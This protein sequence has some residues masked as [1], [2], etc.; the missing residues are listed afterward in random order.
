MRSIC[1]YC[2]SAPGR[3]P[4]Y[5]AAARAFGAAL[6]RRGLG[7]VYGG[8]SVGLMGAVADAA[9][10]AGGEVV[11]VIPESLMKKEL[12]HPNITELIVTRSMH[13]RKT[14]MADRADGFVA[15]PGG[16]GTFEELFEI[17][18]WAQLGFHRK[19][20]GVL[21]VAGY[22]DGLLGFLDHARDE[23]LLAPSVRAVL[24]VADDPDALL[25]RFAAWQ[26][27]DVDRWLGRGE[28]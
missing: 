10:A 5:A 25:E 9:I 13:E 23:G 2:G 11:G 4:E 6:A 15:L 28:V 18:T 1:V 12:A 27:P 24:Q 22:Y 17:W 14:V 7:L 3:R 21:N 26:P 16:I 19:P 8:A 20:C